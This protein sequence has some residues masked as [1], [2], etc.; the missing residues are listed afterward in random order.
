ML[1]LYEAENIN[2]VSDQNIMEKSLLIFIAL[3]LPM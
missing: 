3:S 1:D 2:F